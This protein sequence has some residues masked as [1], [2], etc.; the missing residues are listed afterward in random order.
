MAKQL[1]LDKAIINANVITVDKK[2]PRAEAIGIIGDR[3]TAIGRSKEIE[4]DGLGPD[5]D[6]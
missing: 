2:N 3:I 5:Q 4:G 1:C 6:H